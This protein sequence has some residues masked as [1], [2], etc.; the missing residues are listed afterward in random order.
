MGTRS[1]VF[2]YDE[3]NVTIMTH[4]AKHASHNLA[5]NQFLG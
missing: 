1:S 3:Y 5:Q 2:L 4:V